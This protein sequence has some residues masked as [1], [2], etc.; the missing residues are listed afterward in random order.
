MT[1]EELN[2]LT[3]RIIGIAIEVHKELGPGLLEKVYQRCLKIA[4]EEAGMKVDSEVDFP[5]FFRG[6]RVEDEGFRMDLL[7]EDVVTLEI[8]SVK[9]LEDVF[10]KQL[11]TYLRLAN[12]PCGL[13]MNFNEVLLTH[14][15]RRIKNGY[16]PSVPSVTL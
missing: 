5:V 4:L 14:G 10:M 12:K 13:L 3:E 16:L 2:K 15:I 11:G 8:K 1:E 6:R 7:V 9:A